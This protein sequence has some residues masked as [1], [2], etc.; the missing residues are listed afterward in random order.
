[1]RK[2]RESQQPRQQSPRQ[3]WRHLIFDW[4]LLASAL[5]L[6]GAVVAVIADGRYYRDGSVLYWYLM[7]YSYPEGNLSATLA[8]LSVNAVV[9]LLLWVA[10]R[11]LLRAGLPL[12][13]AWIAHTLMVVASGALVMMLF[14]F[15]W[16]AL[17]SSSFGSPGL[18]STWFGCFAGLACGGLAAALGY[19]VWNLTRGWRRISVRAFLLVAASVLAALTI[20]P[21]ALLIGERADS[22]KH[23]ASGGDHGDVYRLAL[24]ET[25]SDGS[26]ALLFRCDGLGIWCR[27]IDSIG[28]GQTQSNGAY[29]TFDQSAQM[30][31]AREDDGHV[32]LTCHVGAAFVGP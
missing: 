1:M 13:R 14:V 7:L 29:L 28:S 4:Y 31:T 30:V 18:L 12:R 2:L 5:V 3:F 27:E 15:A 10:A 11:M 19:A 25:P 21:V 9:L 23:L 26:L 22:Y 6:V 32:L 20:T 17:T 8:A 16:I 24:R